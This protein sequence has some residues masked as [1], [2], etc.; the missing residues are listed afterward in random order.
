MPQAGAGR[1]ASWSS[2]LPFSAPSPCPSSLE[3]TPPG[4]ELAGSED[5]ALIYSLL[6]I[7]PSS[8]LLLALICAP[9][10]LRSPRLP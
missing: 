4:H 2:P 1:P 6:G 5:P 7:L 8:H 3:F 9:R 10:A